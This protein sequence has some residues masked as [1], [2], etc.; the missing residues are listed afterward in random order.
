M[1][2]AHFVQR[3]GALP[4]HPAHLEPLRH[5]HLAT[6]RQRHEPRCPGRQRRR[7]RYP[8]AHAHHRRVPASRA[9]TALGAAAVLGT[10]AGYVVLPLGVL[11]T[12][13]VTG[14]VAP[15]LVAAMWS[16]AAVLAALLVAAV[17]LATRDN[18][19]DGPA[20]VVAWCASRL[21]H[22]P[23]PKNSATA[24]S[25]SVTSSEA[26]SAQR[27]RASSS[28]WRWLSPSPT[29]RRCTSRSSPSAPTSIA[30]AAMAAFVVSNVAGLVPLTPGGLGFVEAGLGPRTDHRRGDTTRG[31]RRHRHVPPRGNLAPLPGRLRR[32]RPLP[33][34]APP[35]T[36]TATGTS[37]M[38]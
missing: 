18:P 16:A 34:S 37:L 3:M 5:R 14:G 19:G 35:P 24:S 10:V 17:R 1:I 30:A 27:A 23:T 4:R 20:D 13:A 25:T 8:A 22:V 32:T 7:G 11:V 33:T 38:Q 29:T 21:G 31:P 2:V 28:S 36:I 12:S 9:A 26:P 6:G 15:R